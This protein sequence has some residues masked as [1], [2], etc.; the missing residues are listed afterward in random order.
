MILDDHRAALGP[1]L[2]GSWNL[3][4]YFPGKD[5]LDFYIM[6]SSLIGVL[7]Y[8]SQSNYAAGGSFQD[9]LAKHR[10]QNGLPAVSIDLGIVKSVG[11]LAEEE[12]TKNIESLQRHGFMALSED[13]VLS[14]VG[15]AIASP[16]SGPLALGISTG[17]TA[18]ADDAPLSRDARFA[19]LKY[20]KRDQDG[21]QKSAAVSG[22]N[23]MAGRLGAASTPEE[24]ASVVVEGIAKK[25][26]DIFM[27][28]ED[29]VVASKSL[30]AFGVDSLVAVEMRNMLAMKAGAEMSIFDI[31]QSLSIT[32]LAEAVVTRS[33][34]VSF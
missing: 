15:N 13:E 10:V 14:A 34:L 24:A 21:G 9:A 20:Q 1:K 5:D 27:V 2:L 18:Q 26:V 30:A 31:M 17:P 3:H 32:A 16:F 12:F 22:T 28:P 8:A 33:S 6:L 19:G 25:L 7:G 23:D 29:E 4:Q 11:Y